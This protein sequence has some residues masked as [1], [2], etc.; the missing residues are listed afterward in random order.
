MEE[1][2]L[3]PSSLQWWKPSHPARF[4]K[5]LEAHYCIK[6]HHKSLVVR[7]TTGSH[8]VA[9]SQTQQTNSDYRWTLS[10]L[11][12]PFVNNTYE[13]TRLCMGEGERERESAHVGQSQSTSMMRITLIF[14]ISWQSL[15]ASTVSAAARF[16]SLLLL[17][18]SVQIMR[19]RK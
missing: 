3:A 8:S 9:G 17:L 1:G 6:L 15:N 7:L 2:Q 13:M 19:S 12:S 14:F 5:S 16:A 10:Y 4:E 11:F 18:M